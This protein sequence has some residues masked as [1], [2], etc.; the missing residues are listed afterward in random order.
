MYTI[1]CKAD[2]IGFCTAI[3][4]KTIGVI[5]TLFRLNWPKLFG[6]VSVLNQI[7]PSKNIWSKIQNLFG[8]NLCFGFEFVDFRQ[9]AK[10]SSFG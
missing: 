1:K 8:R 4:D 5:L 9:Q 3:R 6:S 7:T 10:L 2:I